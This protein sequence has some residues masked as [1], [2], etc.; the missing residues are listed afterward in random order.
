M[1]AVVADVERYPEFL[2]WCISLRVLTRERRDS[3]D[4]LT[5]EMV[6]V[7]HGVRERYVSRVT[8]DPRS[9]T[10]EAVHIEGPF[11]HLVNRWHFE[12]LK[13]GCRIHFSI[14]FAFRNWLL[15]ALAGVAF[16]RTVARMADAFVARAASLYRARSGV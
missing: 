2:P 12:P 16:D 13:S 14:D 11:D 8:M 4:L 5:A 7:Y 1:Y 3:T 9:R 10:I 6:V 15:S